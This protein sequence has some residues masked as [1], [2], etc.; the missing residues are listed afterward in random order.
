MLIELFR[1]SKKMSRIELEK[2]ADL[3]VRSLGSIELGMR[4]VEALELKRIA[5]AL[6]LTFDD[7][8][9][10][11]VKKDEQNNIGDRL[12]RSAGKG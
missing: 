5:L 4:E 6:G 9:P 11:Q 8:V 7:L 3:P 10:K 12:V 2:L 1:R